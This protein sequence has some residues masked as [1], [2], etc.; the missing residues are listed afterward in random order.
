MTR[1]AWVMAMPA[2]TGPFVDFG[3]GFV[4]FEVLAFE[5]FAAGR[6]ALGFELYQLSGPG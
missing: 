2:I 3:G 6:R 1:S 4:D 5:A